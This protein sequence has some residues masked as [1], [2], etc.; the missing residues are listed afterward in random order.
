MY[1]RHSDFSEYRP[2][3]S[4][5]LDEILESRVLDVSGLESPIIIERIELLFNCGLYFVRTTSRD[6]L[7]GIGVSNDR[8]QFSYPILEKQIAPFFIGKDARDLERLLDEVYVYESNYKLAGIPYF[9]C[10]SALEISILDLLGK[11]KGV[12]LGRLFGPRIHEH[13]YVYV[14]SG[15]RHTTPQEELEILRAEVERIGA[16][17]GIRD[18]NLIKPSIGEATRVLLRRVPWKVLVHSL[19]DEAHLGHIYQLAR[20]KGVEL[21]EYPLENY[22]ACGL[23][24]DLADT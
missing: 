8:I 3:T 4:G 7:V 19:R 10:L 9:S 6:G 13:A 22:R 21:V 17:F 20:E 11:A 24:Q 23:I 12:S 1:K 14:S 15:N 2:V 5:Q 16:D 18:I